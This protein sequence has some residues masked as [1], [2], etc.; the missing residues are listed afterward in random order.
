MKDILDVD[1][2]A[3]QDKLNDLATHHYNMGGLRAAE[4]LREMQNKDKQTRAKPAPG[5][6]DDGHTICLSVCIR[7]IEAHFKV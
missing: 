4:L 5:T 2:I 7:L 1:F 6:Y 3:L